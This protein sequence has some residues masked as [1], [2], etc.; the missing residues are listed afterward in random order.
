MPLN[1]FQNFPAFA[2]LAVG[3]RTE[4]IVRTGGHGRILS[5]W[6]TANSTMNWLLSAYAFRSKWSNILRLVVAFFTDKRNLPGAFM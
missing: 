2:F 6:G 4:L 3:K 5:V 1:H